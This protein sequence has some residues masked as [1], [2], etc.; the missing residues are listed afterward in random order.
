MEAWGSCRSSMCTL[1]KFRLVE[2]STGKGST[3][4]THRASVLA[5]LFD[6]GFRFLCIPCLAVTS[7]CTVIEVAIGYTC[8]LEI[9]KKQRTQY[10]LQVTLTLDDGA[11]DF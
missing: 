5:W 4:T 1:S 10:L 11:S 7:P 9:S 3:R 2:L 6:A 8:I